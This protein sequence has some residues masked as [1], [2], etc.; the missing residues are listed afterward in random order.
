MLFKEYGID[1]FVTL[2]KNKKGLLIFGN[3]NNV[4]KNTN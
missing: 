2:D 1:L 4:F 3:R